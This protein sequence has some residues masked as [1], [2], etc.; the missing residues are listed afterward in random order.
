MNPE[1]LIVEAVSEEMVKAL[2]RLKDDTFSVEVLSI[3]VLMSGAATER[4]VKVEMSPLCA[5]MVLT[6]MLLP[7]V[8][9]P[10]ETMRVEKTALL[11]IRSFLTRTIS[12]SIINELI[13]EV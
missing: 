11:A 8:L 12:I 13:L 5:L 1:V 2:G 6:T 4:A 3:W 9:V 7:M 10:V